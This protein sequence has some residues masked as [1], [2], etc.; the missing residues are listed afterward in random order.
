MSRWS[1]QD[2][3]TT[4]ADQLHVS[5]KR[6]STTCR[7]NPLLWLIALPRPYGN[8]PLPAQNLPPAFA[9]SVLHDQYSAHCTTD[10]TTKLAG[11]TWD[12]G[13]LHRKRAGH[14]TRQA[15][16]YDRCTMSRSHKHNP[17]FPTCSGS[18]K[19]GKTV[20]HRKMRAAVRSRLSLE[21]PLPP[22][23]FP[24][25]DEMY[26]HWSGNKDGKGWEGWNYARQYPKLMRK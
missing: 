3:C 24:V 25:P 21:E 20:Y 7:T 9:G 5:W 13:G 26:D 19:Y 23:L 22:V 1:G 11:L 10:C 18:E 17:V 12:T 4:C 2:S 14:C 15:V 8:A 16:R 6:P